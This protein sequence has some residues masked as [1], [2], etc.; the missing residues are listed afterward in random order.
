M[1]T[2]IFG[3]LFCARIIATASIVRPV[4]MRT[5]MSG[6]AALERLDHRLLP[7]FLERA[8]IDDDGQFARRLRLRGA[9]PNG[10]HARQQG[11]GPSSSIAPL[12]RFSDSS[13]AR[14]EANILRPD[15]QAHVARPRARSGTPWR[16]CSCTSSR[17]PARQRHLVFHQP[18]DPAAQRHRRRRWHR[19]Q[20]GRRNRS[21][22]GRMLSAPRCPTATVAGDPERQVRA[23]GRDAAIRAVTT[24]SSTLAVPMKSATKRVAG[25]LVDVRRRA[26]LLD[27][28]AGS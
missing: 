25:L 1:M 26:D 9:G 5:L 14:Q 4:A 28:A 24:A 17:R 16:S 11:L 23:P 3:S 2:S 12:L 10:E 8:A 18:A 7:A 20:P 21:V 13:A 19:P 27:A 6:L 15:Q 22:P